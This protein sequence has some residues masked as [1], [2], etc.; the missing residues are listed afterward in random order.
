MSKEDLIPLNRRPIE[1]A[2]EIQRKGGRTRSPKRNSGAVIRHLR[3]GHTLTTASVQ[4][5]ISSF[6][7]SVAFLVGNKNVGKTETKLLK[8]DLNNDGKVN[9]VDFSIAAYWYKR[10]LSGEIIQKEIER[11]N[12][13]GTINLV[14]FSIMAYYW[15]G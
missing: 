9:L 11:L 6:G 7:A 1:E 3:E 14:D 12:G 15:T 4:N 10:Q 8:G 5:L 13:D 2:R